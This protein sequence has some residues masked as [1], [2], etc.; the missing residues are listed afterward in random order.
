[1]LSDITDATRINSRARGYKSTELIY[2]TWNFTTTC[3]YACRYC[4]SEL[5]DGAW[6]FPEYDKALDF[7]KSLKDQ[8]PKKCYITTELLGGEPTMWPKLIPFLIEI[9]EL[10]LEGD[11]K[12]LIMLDTNLSRTNRWW[13]KFKD[14]GLYDMTV[15]N[16]SFHSDFCDPDFYYS[17][18]EIISDTYQTHSNMMADPKHFWTVI[19]L[20]NRIR[21]KLPVDFCVKVLRPDLGSTELIDGY[22]DDMLDYINKEQLGQYLYP[23]SKFNVPGEKV[24]WPLDVHSNDERVNWQAILVKRQHKFLDWQC[25]AGS[26]RLYIQPNGDVYPCSRLI[27]V[28]TTPNERHFIEDGTGPNRKYIMGNINKGNVRLYKE[29]M[30]CPEIYCSCKMDVV[31]DKYKINTSV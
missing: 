26:K 24:K 27:D 1:M 30:P 19:D 25:S 28:Y 7:F 11:Q 8:L 22:T 21:K 6:G 18:L 20:M 2:I 9:R 4:P 15:I 16:S 23:R 10:F 12:I 17:N 5:H 3:N 31:C 13:Q 29:Y 14:A